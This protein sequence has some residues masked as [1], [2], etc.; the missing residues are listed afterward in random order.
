MNEQEWLGLSPDGR[1]VE[2][3][4][5]MRSNQ[6]IF[7]LNDEHGCVMLNSEDEDGIPVWPSASLAALWATEE[8]SQCEPMAISLKDW[9]QRWV[10]G[11]QKDELCVVVCPL[12]GEDSELL[13]PEEF[14]DMLTR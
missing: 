10:S 5:V 8:W 11:M 3:V 7:I 14:A 2:S 9:M 4:K 13:S 12:P 1:L 6:Q